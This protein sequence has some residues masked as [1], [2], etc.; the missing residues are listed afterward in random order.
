MRD[1]LVEFE[2]NSLSRFRD[3]Q[4]VFAMVQNP[5]AKVQTTI[6]DSQATRHVIHRVLFLNGT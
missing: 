3:W 2:A 1:A 4:K 6:D 5:F